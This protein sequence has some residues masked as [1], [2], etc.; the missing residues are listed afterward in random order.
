MFPKFQS[1]RLAPFAVVALSL[2][3]LSGC[4]LSD[5]WDKEYAC[6]GQER[7][8]MHMQGH[9][10]SEN[11]EKIYPT[12]VD[13]HIRSDFVLVKSHQ[14]QAKRE[15]DQKLSFSTTNATSGT[16]GTD[17]TSGTSGSNWVTGNFDAKTNAL[18][19]IQSQTLMV[20]GSP[21]EGRTTGQYVCTVI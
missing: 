21:Q 14:M 20:D 9:P 13:F 1:A 10:E 17:A 12:T 5:H 2:L 3:L 18:T 19:L 7:S 15:P 11:Y 8:T 16:K 4:R 6:K